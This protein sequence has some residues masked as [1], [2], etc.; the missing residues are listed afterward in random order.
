M[1]A[2]AVY[3]VVI[4]DKPVVPEDWPLWVTFLRGSS[5]FNWIFHYSS[6]EETD[7]EARKIW[8]W[9]RGG[10]RFRYFSNR[11]AY[12]HVSR[13]KAHGIEAHVEG[14]HIEWVTR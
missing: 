10:E 8:Q 9:W 5:E 11:S 7:L 13:L 3:R 4:D 14:G 1:S 2:N 6:P 12:Q